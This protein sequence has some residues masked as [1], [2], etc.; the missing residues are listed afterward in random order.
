[1]RERQTEKKCAL[2]RPGRINRGVQVI[3]RK[4]GVGVLIISNQTKSCFK[5]V[6]DF[7]Q[8]L[9]GKCQSKQNEFL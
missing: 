9:L 7:V 1:M 5:A 3:S 2:S 8:N 6:F 4:S